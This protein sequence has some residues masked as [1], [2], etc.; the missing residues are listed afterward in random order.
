[1]TKAVN[2]L[3]QNDSYSL[4]ICIVMEKIVHGQIVAA[5]KGVVSKCKEEAGQISPGHFRVCGS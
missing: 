3:P 2:I 1:M 5:K 4:S